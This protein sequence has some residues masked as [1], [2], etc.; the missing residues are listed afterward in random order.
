MPSGILIINKPAGMTS[1]DVVD[2]IRRITGEQRVGHAGTLDPFATGVLVVG[3][4]REATKALGWIAKDTE[5]RYRATVRLGAESDTDDREGTVRVCEDAR[6][7]KKADVQAALKTFVGTIQQTPPIYSSKKISGI[8]AHRRVRR[9]ES[10]H[11]KPHPITI[12]SITLRSYA[13]PLVEFDIACSS[14]TYIRSL[15]RDLGSA[16][17]VGGCLEALERTAVGSYT[18]AMARDLPSLATDPFR[19]L[20][21]TPRPSRG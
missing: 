15:A 9:G 5:K 1:H 3:V 4:G 7:R 13:W 10:V 6:P 2:A 17:G 20:L 18:I 12:H 16:L 11:L 19:A 8:P 21:P 14:G